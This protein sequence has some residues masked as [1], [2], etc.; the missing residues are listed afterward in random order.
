MDQ[1]NSVPLNKFLLVHFPFSPL[2]IKRLILKAFMATSIC[3]AIVSA[4]YFTARRKTNTTSAYKRH[5]LDLVFIFPPSFH[6]PYN[7]PYIE[8][9]ESGG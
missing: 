6:I 3:D 8:I 2:L 7:F 4:T 5:C 9:K 1:A